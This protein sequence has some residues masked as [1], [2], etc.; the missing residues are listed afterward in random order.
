L[1][2]HLFLFKNFGLNS[3]FRGNYIFDRITGFS[4]YLGI[5]KYPVYPVNLVKEFTPK[6]H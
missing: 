2:S 1:I 5:K 6:F 3:I 4:G